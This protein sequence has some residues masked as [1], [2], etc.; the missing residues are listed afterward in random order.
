MPW[1]LS[2]LLLTEK[3]IALAVMLQTVELLQLRHT[4][5]DDG[6][7]QWR[8]L[9]PE[10]EIFP[11]PI[12]RLL[13]ALLRYRAFLVV[14]GLRLLAA[15][16]MLAFSQITLT[17]IL[18]C[19]TVLICLRWRG[20]FNGG[21]DYMTIVVLS[22]LLVAQLFDRSPM[23]TLGCLWYIALQS[24]LS[25]FIAGVVKLRRA[26]WRTGRALPGFLAAGVY[27][28]GGFERVLITRPIL[29][30]LLSWFILLFECLFPLAFLHQSLC[31]AFIGCA[32]LFHLAN[33]A[34]FGL[35]RFFFVWVSTYPALLF[36]SQLGVGY[37]VL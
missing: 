35:N 18:L 20:T 31:A 32:A 17:A 7:W 25:Y 34:V 24:C 6:I 3:L 12:P 33:V 19:S 13:D 30:L 15:V 36:C 28:R 21:S 2:P 1:S 9:K 16:A 14:L 5:A 29:T 23:V 27:G 26:S 4:F 10:Y 8:L 37:A 22:S 11:A